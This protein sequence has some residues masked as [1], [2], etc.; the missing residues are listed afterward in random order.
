MTNKPTEEH[1]F[2]CGKALRWLKRFGCCPYVSDLHTHAAERPD[3]IGWKNG[4][5]IVI[6]VKTS[7]QDFLRDFRKKHREKGVGCFRF[8]LCR[9]GLIMPDD[10][11]KGW[12]LLWS[13]KKGKINK[14]VFPTGNIMSGTSW[15]KFHN[16]RDVDEEILIL[17]SINRRIFNDK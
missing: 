4:L 9:E 5:S 11:P 8:Y 1:A 3:A 15:E 14:T 6:E 7:R 2:L 16:E 17:C 10:L 13:D 12:G